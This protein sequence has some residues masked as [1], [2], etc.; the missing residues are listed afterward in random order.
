MSGRFTTCDACH[1]IWPVVEDCAECDAT[2]QL[3]REHA[4]DLTEL[5]CGCQA[6]TT[7]RAYC[8]CCCLDVEVADPARL[9][10]QLRAW[11][12]ALETKA[13]EPRAT[14]RPWG[15]RDDEWRRATEATAAWVA[16]LREMAS[17]ARGRAVALEAERRAA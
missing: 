13:A 8:S 4:I 9:P 3:W 12:E 6:R 5:V 17:R 14:E 2:G 15:W 16:R 1:G 11:A 7:V 10:E